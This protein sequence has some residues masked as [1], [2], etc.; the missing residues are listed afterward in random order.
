[1][2]RQNVTNIF[3]INLSISDLLVIGFALPSRVNSINE[4]LII[5]SY[6]RKQIAHHPCWQAL[7]KVG[8]L[9]LW[10]DLLCKS[11]WLL[12][13][14]SLMVS[15][16]TMTAMAME[17]WV[18]IFLKCG[19]ASLIFTARN[20]SFEG[21]YTTWPVRCFNDFIIHLDQVTIIEKDLNWLKLMQ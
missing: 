4:M 13:Y 6:D 7:N 5:N 12:Y 2:N 21:M 18:H 9:W 19:C 14:T 11:V 3:I 15:S 17:R 1:M 10:G 20:I 16:F 8:G